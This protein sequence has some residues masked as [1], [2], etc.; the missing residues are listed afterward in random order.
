MKYLPEGWVG[1]PDLYFNEALKRRILSYVNQ[2][3]ITR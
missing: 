2:V 1:F 3:R